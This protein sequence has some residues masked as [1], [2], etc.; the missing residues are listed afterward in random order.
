[1]AETR[2]SSLLICAGRGRWTGDPAAVERVG[3]THRIVAARRCEPGDR[4]AAAG[5]VEVSQRIAMA[6]R[7]EA[8]AGEAL[9]QAAKGVAGGD[10]LQPIGIAQ[11]DHLG[12]ALPGVGE[13]AAEPPH[14]EQSRLVEKQDGAR[15]ETVGVLRPGALEAGESAGLDAGSGFQVRRALGGQRGAE[16]LVPPIL[17]IGGDGAGDFG[18]GLGVAADDLGEGG[19]GRGMDDG[20]ALLGGKPRFGKLAGGGA[21]CLLGGGIALPGGR[22]AGLGGRVLCLRGGV[23]AGMVPRRQAC[24]RGQE[25]R[26]G[27]EVVASGVAAGAG[28]VLAEIEDPIVAQGFADQ[29]HALRLVER[30]AVQVGRG[31]GGAGLGEAFEQLRGAM[32]QVLDGPRTECASGRQ[33]GGWLGM[34]RAMLEEGLAEAE[35]ELRTGERPVDARER[36]ELRTIGDEKAR[37]SRSRFE[38]EAARGQARLEVA[39]AGGFCEGSGGLLAHSVGKWLAAGA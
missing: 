5:R 39:P 33:D 38:A 13:D 26:L 16:H 25:P 10:R 18:P 8:G 12:V 29:G 17:A 28:R 11:Q 31:E 37:G 14:V 4:T 23:E 36:S 22:M 7:V 6:G 2:P 24:G 27:V 21:A 30:G 1:M 32:P 19:L 35:G 34:G 3:A 20:G 15:M 9:E